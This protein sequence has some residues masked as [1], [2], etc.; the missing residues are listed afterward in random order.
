MLWE[1]GR[2]ETDYSGVWLIAPLLRKPGARMVYP[3]HAAWAVYLVISARQK[4]LKPPL[5]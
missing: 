4:L 3:F 5:T 2:T 1:F